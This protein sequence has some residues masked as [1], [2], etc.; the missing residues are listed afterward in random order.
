[1]AESALAPWLLSC[2]ISA[3]SADW[4]SHHH[5]IRQQ[6]EVTTHHGE[7][8]LSWVLVPTSSLPK[9][10]NNEQKEPQATFTVTSVPS[11][12][13]KGDDGLENKR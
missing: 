5:C 6:Q 7:V 13:G 8:T 2:P 4:F 12:Q 1:M 3:V 11:Q 9:K 10:A